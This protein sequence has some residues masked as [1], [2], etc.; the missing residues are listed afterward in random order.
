MSNARDISNM[1]ESQVAK[2]WVNFNGR[3]ASSPFTVD[4]GGIRNSFNVSSVTDN[5]VGIYTVNLENA[6]ENSNYC[7]A[8][9]AGDLTVTYGDRQLSAYPLT[10]STCRVVTGVTANTNTFDSA[11]CNIVI[12]V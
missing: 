4:N 9:S 3:T 5:G 8:G 7:I 1:N 6:L 2:A 11:Q 12:Y 10:S